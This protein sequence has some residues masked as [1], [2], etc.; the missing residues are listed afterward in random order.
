MLLHTELCAWR[1]AQLCSEYARELPKLLSAQHSN[2]SDAVEA[3]C[4]AGVEAVVRSRR[5]LQD[6]SA[7]ASLVVPEFLVD[8][9]HESYARRA[10]GECDKVAAAFEY[11]IH[12]V[13]CQAGLRFGAER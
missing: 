10:L 12:H 5:K 8:V 13:V 7:K 11:G 4:R 6:A 9:V 3:Q 2:S 1:L